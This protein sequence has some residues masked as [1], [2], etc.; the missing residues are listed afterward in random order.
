VLWL[1]VAAWWTLEAMEGILRHNSTVKLPYEPR[2][3]FT[4]WAR[5]R[6]RR[7]AHPALPRRA[8]LRTA[9]RWS[10]L[11]ASILLVLPS[12]QG[13]RAEHPG[14]RLLDFG[15]VGT[16]AATIFVSLG[17][18]GSSSSSARSSAAVNVL[19]TVPLALSAFFAFQR[20]SCSPCSRGGRGGRRARWA[21][22]PASAAHPRPESLPSRPSPSSG[23][24]RLAVIPAITSQK[25]VTG[26]SPPPSPTRSG[27]P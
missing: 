9:G 8:R 3:S 12:P 17:V 20:A 13:V 5:T 2:R 25:S 23:S 21:P 11:S 6:W 27:L 18:I 7:G 10:A 26:R 14:L 16:D 22:P 1:T 15:S 24:A 4:S 19:C